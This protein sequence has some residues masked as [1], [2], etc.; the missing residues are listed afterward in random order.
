MFQYVLIC[1]WLNHKVG[2]LIAYDVKLNELDIA[3]NDS[4]D[5]LFVQIRVTSY[6]AIQFSCLSGNFYVIEILHPKWCNNNCGQPCYHVA[7]TVIRPDI[8]TSREQRY[9]AVLHCLNIIITQS[10]QEYLGGICYI[11]RWHQRNITVFFTE[12]DN[13]TWFCYCNVLH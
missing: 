7:L 6:I 13:H 8:K 5:I 12:C 9:T 11:R 1:K 10:L 2:Y 4:I 3:H